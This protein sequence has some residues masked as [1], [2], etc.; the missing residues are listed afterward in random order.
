M[1]LQTS[2]PSAQPL[3]SSLRD[4]QPVAGSTRAPRRPGTTC[5]RVGRW[6]L[7]AI[8]AGVLALAVAVA[9]ASAN[10][11][12][13]ETEQ[14]WPLSVE[15]NVTAEGILE[16]TE[17]FQWD[18]R[19]IKAPFVRALPLFVPRVEQ[20][21][22]KFEYSDFS[23][24]S[25]YALDLTV[26]DDSHQL[27]ARLTPTPEANEQIEQLQDDESAV[28]DITFSYKVRGALSVLSPSVTS[29]NEMFW[30]PLASGGT[31]RTSLDF[32]I[33]AQSVMKDSQCSVI[34]D[35]GTLLGWNDAIDRKPADV[36]EE[37]E[38]TPTPSCKVR[39][40]STEVIAKNLNRYS[41]VIVRAN[42]PMGTLTD[43]SAISV[44]EP[45]QQDEEEGSSDVFD[46]TW[47]ENIDFGL[48]QGS[49]AVL[50]LL[51]GGA[52][53]ALALG[54]AF[55][56]RRLPDFRFA[57]TAHGDVHT[58]RE[59]NERL[60][61]A[62][63][64]TSSS[65]SIVKVKKDLTGPARTDLPSDLPAG[66]SGG[67]WALELSWNDI[68]A[69]LAELA[70]N[71]HLQ[72]RVAP[73]SKTMS[74]SE[75]G[76]AP[77]AAPHKEFAHL[78]WTLTRIES[79]TPLKQYEQAFMDAMFANGA[80]AKIQSL[81]SAFAPQLL[82]VLALIGQELKN[83][84]LVVSPID[85]AVARRSRR[86]QRTALGRAYAE[87]LE[88]VGV[89]LGRTDQGFSDF[90]APPDAGL[91]EDYLPVAVALGRA[92]EWASEFDRAQVPFALPCWFE[93]DGIDVGHYTDFVSL[94]R[95][96]L[97]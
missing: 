79:A 48:D 43:D 5:R 32:T 6:L 3:I 35:D 18:T 2:S 45:D 67:L 93:A 58:A 28:I 76:S 60:A 36:E 96:S 74:S 56:T 61:S 51:A 30:A 49:G 75:P 8:G 59:L 41:T 78:E 39:P 81:H 77:E 29:S 71:G 34:L 69:V 55:F 50:P 14:D 64:S 63:P 46:P 17:N 72:V 53:V 7:S 83:Q 87:H 9:P 15:A 44:I 22:R 89:A 25:N 91:F 16:V 31:T 92:D 13:D 70:H 84:N 86:M 27:L 94:W 68:W 10:D 85:N 19:N 95:R 97:V 33:T 90:P 21:W 54:I 4:T 37:L 20:S 80:E 65:I 42:Y 52:V 62:E 12:S 38:G 57:S 88:S 73:G 47:S 40:S 11:A 24:D 26:A 82:E 66:L 1:R 23:V